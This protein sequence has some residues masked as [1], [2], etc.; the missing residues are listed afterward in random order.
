MRLESVR[1]ALLGA[2]CVA[3]LSPSPVTASDG[4]TSCTFSS[5]TV[6]L[7][8]AADHVIRLYAID[9]LIKFADLTNY[10]NRG[11]C[12]SATVRNT[13]RVRITEQVAG[14]SRL[15]LDQ[16]L[17]R[18][19]PGRTQE[20]TGISEVEVYLGTLEDI[21]LMGRPV[22]N[23]VVIGS[24][25]INLNGDGDVDLIGQSLVQIHLFLGDGDDYVAATGGSG[26]GSAWAPGS[27]SSFLLG[28]QAGDGDDVIYGT[29]AA[30]I[31]RGDLGE[32]RISGRGG[33]DQLE[34]GSHDDVIYGGRG[35][36]I[37]NP[38]P[39]FDTVDAG[40]GNDLI[41]A[42]DSTADT[43]IGGSGTD[44]A[45]VDAEDSVTGVETTTIGP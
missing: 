1:A 9:G 17:G 24:G 19:G 28:V 35:T 4:I 30:D 34:G 26:T 10:A 27:T 45:T 13:D 38:G 32:D 31:L 7:Y 8:L 22:R 18:F 37:I 14:N 16:Q 15:Q 11:Q 41:E 25:G 44:R 2:V 3:T 21:W 36:D 20:S 29:S 33:P 43:I 12:G 5:G 23:E 6:R 42:A 39:W 40:A